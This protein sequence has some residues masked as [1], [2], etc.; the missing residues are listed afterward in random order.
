MNMAC[1]KPSIK[2]STSPAFEWQYKL[3]RILEVEPTEQRKEFEKSTTKE[4]QAKYLWSFYS[5]RKNNQGDSM[6]SNTYGF[7]R[8]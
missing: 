1:E 2:K 8:K 7:K 5:N 6:Y 3:E 4:E